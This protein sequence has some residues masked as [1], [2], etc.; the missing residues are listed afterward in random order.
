[1]RTFK[2]NSNILI[3]ALIFEIFFSWI[4]TRGSSNSCQH[5]HMDTNKLNYHKKKGDFARSL[6]KYSCKSFNIVLADSRIQTYKLT[7]F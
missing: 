3:T 5:I 6:T 7:H 2:A 4:S 1:M